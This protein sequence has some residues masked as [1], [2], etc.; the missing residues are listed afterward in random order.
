MNEQLARGLFSALACA[1]F[2]AAAAEHM[3][4]FKQLGGSWR[5]PIV[6]FLMGMALF[7]SMKVW[8]RVDSL[9]GNLD[10]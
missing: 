1:V 8:A 2:I 6:G 3:L 5:L 9:I 10:G 4:W 7:E